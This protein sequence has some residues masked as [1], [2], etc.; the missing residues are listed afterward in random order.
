MIGLNKNIFILKKTIIISTRTISIYGFTKFDKHVGIPGSV[1]LRIVT[2][3]ENEGSSTCICA[4]EIGT[5][6]VWGDSESE[7]FRRDLR[8]LGLSEIAVEHSLWENL[9]LLRDFRSDSKAKKRKIIKLN[10]ILYCR[11]LSN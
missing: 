3:S 9:F 1:G 7:W 6:S 2:S 5:S 10:E 4:C 8:F 11:I